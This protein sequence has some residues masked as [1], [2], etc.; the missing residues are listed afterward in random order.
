MATTSV[1]YA[2]LPLRFRHVLRRHFLMWRK[3]AAISLLAHV[4]EPLI[5]LL[6]VGYGLGRSLPDMEGLS[7]PAFLA[8]GMIFNAVTTSASYEGLTAV[9]L[10]WKVDRTWDGILHAPMTAVDVI[11]GEWCWVAAKASITALGIVT[12]VC[13]LGLLPVGIVPWVM[14]TAVLLGL[15]MAAIA[16]VVTALISAEELQD[17]YFSLFLVPMSV[18]SGVF[19]PIDRLP[20]SLQTL[21]ELLPLY[22]AT[23]ATRMLATGAP[24]LHVIPHLGI[25]CLYAIVGI[26]TAVRVIR[27]RVLR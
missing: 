10:R 17:Y 14:L 24:L 16:L 22:H 25:I 23:A 20:A 13:A 18:V 26:V 5:W 1:M 27:N 6:G 12:V 8:A 15:A 9:F 21:A 7:Y 4:I 11:L 3:V 2:T 19:F